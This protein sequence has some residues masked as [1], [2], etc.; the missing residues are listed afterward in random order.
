M[1]VCSR[2]EAEGNGSV[3][4]EDLWSEDGTDTRPAVPGPRPAMCAT[5]YC[6]PDI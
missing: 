5:L 2:Q 4:S 6:H 3:P 1:A